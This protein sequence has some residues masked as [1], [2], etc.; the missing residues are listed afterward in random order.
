MPAFTLQELSGVMDVYVQVLPLS[1]S[2]LAVPR[3]GCETTVEWDP[4]DLAMI[5][6]ELRSHIILTFAGQV[7][8]WME[9]VP[10]V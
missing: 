3:S 8:E 1:S 9:A 2:P 4:Q 10:A 7:P 6:G 5:G